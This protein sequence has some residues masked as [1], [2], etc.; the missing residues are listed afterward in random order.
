MRTIRRLPY[1]DDVRIAVQK[2]QWARVISG[3]FFYL[4]SIAISAAKA[5]FSVP[6]GDPLPVP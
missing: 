4:I 5:S 2:T 6:P 3:P 1:L